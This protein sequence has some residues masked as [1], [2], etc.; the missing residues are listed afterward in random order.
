MANSIA[1]FCKSYRNDLDKVERLIDSIRRHN[2][3]ALPFFLCIPRADRSLFIDRF[4]MSGLILIHDEDVLERDVEQSWLSQQLV[5]FH[6][7]ETRLADNYFIVD[8][9]DVFLRPF[10]AADF[11]FDGVH[12]YLVCTSGRERGRL[13]ALATKHHRTM[14]AIDERIKGHKQQIMNALGRTGH[15]VSFQPG[16]IF[17]AA[18][19]RKMVTELMEPLGLSFLDLLLTAPFEAE[20]YGDYVLRRQPVPFVPID[21]LILELATPEIIR[22]E[23]NLDPTLRT[24][25]ERYLAV[26]LPTYPIDLSLPDDG[27]ATATPLTAIDH[28][29]GVPV[30]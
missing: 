17:C 11:L 21:P 10:H 14:V 26:R 22:F 18:V 23:Q 15:Q 5:K 13:I 24:I 30:L 8:S 1:V 27:E 7:H 19:C 29:I 4:G 25:R 16:P 6:F 28:E 3:E 2:S 20:W 12:P 9:D